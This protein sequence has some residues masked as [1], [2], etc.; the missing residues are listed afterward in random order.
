MY[1]DLMGGYGWGVCGGW[2]VADEG[3]G[4]AAEVE[5]TEVGVEE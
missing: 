4:G 3:C 1:T 2:C 5:G